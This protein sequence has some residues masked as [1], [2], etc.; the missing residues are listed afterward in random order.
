MNRRGIVRMTPKKFWLSTCQDIAL[1][2]R[3]ATEALGSSSSPA[4]PDRVDL[5]GIS[6]SG[7]AAGNPD[8]NC[9]PLAE[10]AKWDA[11]SKLRPEAADFIYESLDERKASYAN[12][13]CLMFIRERVC[14]TRIF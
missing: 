11:K 6:A 4:S 7:Y 12:D 1:Q 10:H 5:T 13:A 9:P 14:R 2:A 3:I 8:G